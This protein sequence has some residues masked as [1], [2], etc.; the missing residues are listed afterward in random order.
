[1]LKVAFVYMNDEENIGRGAGYVAGAIR[2]TGHQ[3]IYYDTFYISIEKTAQNVLKNNA[4]V[5]MIS[6]MTLNFKEA[7]N[8]ITLVKQGK[9]IPVLI[10]GI[11]IMIEKQKI[12]EDHP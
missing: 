8:L 10:G 5:L 1:M 2:A 11:H 3:L 9:D 6:T 12:L 4:D 7:L